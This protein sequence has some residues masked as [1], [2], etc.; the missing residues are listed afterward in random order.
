MLNDAS[1]AKL[2]HSPVSFHRDGAVLDV[3]LLQAAAVVGDALNSDITDHVTTFYT[4]LFQ[5]GTIFR[6]HFESKICDV[7]L[8]NV[9][10]AEAGA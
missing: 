5:I 10:G 3:E 7:T 9:Q 1:L 2:L 4:Q 6:E 8:A